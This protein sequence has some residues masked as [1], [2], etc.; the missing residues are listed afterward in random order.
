VPALLNDP[1]GDQFLVAFY[2]APELLSFLHPSILTVASL[3][4]FVCAP[5]EYSAGIRMNWLHAIVL[6]RGI[7][8]SFLMTILDAL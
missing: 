5:S 6:A 7:Y 8:S 1:S 3:D 4:S 2:A